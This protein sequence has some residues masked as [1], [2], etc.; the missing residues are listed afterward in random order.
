MKNCNLA[1]SDYYKAFYDTAPVGFYVTSIKDGTFLKANFFCV[2]MLGYDSFEDMQKE[3]KSADLYDPARRQELV[4]LIK[5][6][7]CTTG[8]EIELK[9]PNG[10]VKWVV[11][12]ARTCANGDCIEGSITDVT[13][14]KQL[15]AKLEEYKMAEINTL[16][17]LQESCQARIDA[18]DT[19]LEIAS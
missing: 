10:D 13:E 12:T 4:N 18:F 8:F 9:L 14:R 17:N 11:L 19:N 3:I 5:E 6:R 16:Q 15:E 1:T 7:G 2:N